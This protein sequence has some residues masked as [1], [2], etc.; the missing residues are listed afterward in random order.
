MP[1]QNTIV[2]VQGMPPQ[3][4]RFGVLITLSC[5][6]QENSK[7]RRGFP[8]NPPYLPRDRSFKRKMN[9][10][11]PLPGS[12]I[13]HQGLTLITGEG[14]GVNTTPRQTLSQTIVSAIILLRACSSFLKVIYCPIRGTPPLFPIKMVFSPEF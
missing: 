14:R 12:F 9:V 7:I 10:I 4:R 8:L 3:I 6:H 1:L 5:R 11:K 2:G 13:S